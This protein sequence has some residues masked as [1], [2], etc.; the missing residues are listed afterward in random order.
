MALSDL[1]L[2]TEQ[3]YYNPPPPL[4]LLIN[5]NWSTTLI[6]SK[7]LAQAYMLHGKLY[8]YRIVGN[9]GEIFNLAIWQILKKITKLKLANI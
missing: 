1:D 7:P 4:I 6:L 5:L 3:L 2:G 8:E 9:F